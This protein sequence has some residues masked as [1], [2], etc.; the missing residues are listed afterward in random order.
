M[1]KQEVYRILDNERWYQDTVRK[2]NKNETRDDAEKSVSEFILYM[3][4]TLDKAK[5]AIYMLNEA[6]ALALIRKTTAL[7]I[8]TGEAFGFPERLKDD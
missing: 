5:K 4:Y 7:G 3:E 6:E 2:E 8:A 1:E